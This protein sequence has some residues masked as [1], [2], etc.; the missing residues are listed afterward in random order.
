MKKLRLAIVCLLFAAGSERF[1]SAADDPLLKA[2]E[3]YDKGQVKAAVIELKSLLQ[4]SPENAEAR[5]LLGEAYLKLGDAPSA[6]KELEKARDLNLPKERWINMLAQAYLLESQPKILLDKLLPDPSL[7]APVNA[8]LQ[9]LRGMAQ[10]GVKEEADKAQDSFKSALQTDPNCVEALMGMSMLEM[11]R[12]HLKES[13]DYAAQATVKAPK[14]GQAWLL[15]AETKRAGNDL[16]GALD[17]YMHSVEL[18][19]FNMKALLGRA[20]IYVALGNLPEARKDIEAL[21]KM[22]G[23]ADIPLAL[24]TEG[25]IDFQSNKLDE[26]K[27]KLTKVLNASPDHLPTNFLLGAISF[28]KNELEQA[29]F[30]LSK[31][32]TAAPGNL[33]AVKLLAAARL[34]RGMPEEAVKLLQPWAD[35]EQKDPQLFAILGSA[36]LK[37]KQYDQGIN[38]LSKAAEIAPDVASVRAELG[39]GKIAAG[40]MDQ[41]VGDLKSAVGIDPSLMEADA[42]I[43]LALIQ[44]KKFDEAIAEAGKIKAKRKDDPMADNLMGAAYMAKGDVEHARESWQNALALKPDYTPANL[45]LAKMALSQNKPNDAAKEYDKILKRDPK[46]LSALIGQAQ[47]AEMGKDYPK[48][49]SL[50]EDARQKNPKEISPAVMLTRYYL[51]QGKGGQALSIAGDAAGSNPDNVAALQNLGQAQLGANQ[52]GN[53]VATFKQLLVKQPDSPELHHLLAQALYKTGDKTA[54][55]KEWD[56][57]L[58]KAPEYVPALLA[59]ADLAMQDK[60]FADV[61]KTADLI[62]AKFPKSPLGYQLEGDVQVAQKQT[63]KSVPPYETAYQLAPSSYLARRLYIARRELH[64][65]QAAFD[66]LKK[67]LD[68]SSQDAESWGLLA[69][70]LQEAGKMK[71]AATAYEKAYEIRPDNLVLLNNL[72][73]V[74]QELGDNRALPFAEKLVAT[75]GAENKSEILD[76]VGWVYLHNGKE[77]KGLLLL[78]QAALQDARNAHIRFHLATAFAKTGKKEDARKELERLLKENPQFSERGKAEALLKGL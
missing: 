74:Y 45:N 54:A 71:E 12:Q 62:K 68:K 20:S 43:V 47:I 26:A 2:K 10:L 78:Q 40:K 56:Q 38:Y 49:V 27:E 30:Y 16:P 6:A 15:L 44:Q 61:T 7:P 24:Y 4:Q 63:A 72:A 69:A 33:P 76:T 23:A 28:Q 57:A 22:P 21:K 39:L 14:N 29:E 1:A 67:W 50:L 59:K 11:S 75:P 35:K 25:L 66:G 64:Q 52:A 34:K 32:V 3:S 53:A 19:P 77:D 18:Q 73:W 31:V 42:T 37:N 55:A 13:S 58:K 8:K 46:N 9:A 48:M 36:Y 17:A 65:D 41:G 70:G 60:R 5:L 51:S